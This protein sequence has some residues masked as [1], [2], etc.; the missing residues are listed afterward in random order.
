[1]INC[2]S[3]PYGPSLYGCDFDHGHGCGFL[4]LANPGWV[5]DHEFVINNPDPD[6]IPSSDH[7][8]GPYSPNIQ[9]NCL[10]KRLEIYLYQMLTS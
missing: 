1:M 2:H 4:G 6:R 7:T 8:I 3:G 9:G 5:L 10:V